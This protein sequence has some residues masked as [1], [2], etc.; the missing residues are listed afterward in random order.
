MKRHL[1]FY[2]ISAL[3]FSCSSTK[4]LSQYEISTEKK[5]ALNEIFSGYSYTMLETME[6]AILTNVKKI[7]VDDS[8]ISVQDK[9][10]VVVFNKEGKFLSKINAYGRGHNEYMSL[11]DYAIQDSRFY[12][13]S[14]AQKAILVYDISGK[15]IKNLKLDDWYNHLVFSGKDVVI[16][17][18]E[19]S[20][21]SKK[22]F[23]LYDV[24]K[25]RKIRVLD[26]FE[27]N[28]NMLF[29]DYTPFCGKSENGYYV[30]HCFDHDIY[31]ITT[32]DIK[33]YASFSFANK[34]QLPAGAPSMSYFDLFE[35]TQY[36]SVV[37]NMELYCKLESCSYVTFSMFGTEGG[38]LPYVC[39]LNSDGSCQ[40]ACIGDKYSEKFPYITKPMA[41]Y[42]DNLVS[43][44]DP[45]LILS[46]EK[47]HNIDTFSSKGLT[48]ESNWVVFFNKLSH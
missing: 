24:A 8:Y 4:D 37:K 16:L 15:F 40:T 25:G 27:R 39:R 45:S 38:I 12:I 26:P 48:K 19:N 29:G 6:D 44:C 30:T 9:N 2:I 3:L 31:E 28:E 18:S 7:I 10:H 43:V 32:E 17:S 5:V 21:M 35:A 41:I 11:D 47:N 42:K 23:L 36:K 1:I 33:P 14:R 13:L 34:G 22:S 46:I 20:N